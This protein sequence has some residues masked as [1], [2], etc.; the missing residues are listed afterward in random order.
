MGPNAGGGGVA[1]AGS[2]PMTRVVHMEP[3]YFGDLTP[4]LTYDGTRIN[5]EKTQHT[6]FDVVAFGTNPPP[7]PSLI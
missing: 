6:V 4:Y 2:Q 3:T 7:P 5:K 1:V